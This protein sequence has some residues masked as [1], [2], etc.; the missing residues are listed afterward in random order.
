[1]LAEHQFRSS[2]LVA[3]DSLNETDHRAIKANFRE[4]FGPRDQEHLAISLSLSNDFCQEV[5]PSS[6]LPLSI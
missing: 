1:M 2:S 6:D 4:V 5:V 3:E